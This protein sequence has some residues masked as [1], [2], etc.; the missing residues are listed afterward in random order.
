MWLDV[1]IINFN[2]KLDQIIKLKIFINWIE[3][4]FIYQDNRLNFL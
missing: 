4:K 2:F 3:V 1:K